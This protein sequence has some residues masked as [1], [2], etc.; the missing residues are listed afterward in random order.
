MSAPVLHEALTLLAD[1]VV[2]LLLVAGVLVGAV[3]GA[4]PGLS[5]TLAVALL[6]PFT[7]D[8]S[9]MPALAM[10]VGVYCGAIYGGSVPAILFRTPGTPASAATVT[11]GYALTRRGQSRRALSVAAFSAMVGGAIGTALLLLLAPQIASFAL[12]F[13]PPEYFALA[14][15]GLSMIVSVSGGSVLKSGAVALFGLLIATV[16]M[17][18]I[19]GYP[20]FLFG[21]ASLLEGVPFIPALIGLFALAEVFRALNNRVEIKQDDTGSVSWPAPA[22]VRRCLWTSTRSGLLGT[23][24]GSTPGAGSDIAAFM[25]YSV[26]RQRAKPGED[27]GHGEI[28]GV[29]A[30]EAAKTASIS[31]AMVPLLSLGIPGDSVTAVMIGAFILHGVQ[32]GPLL[33]AQNGGLAY[34]ILGTVLIAHLLVFLAAILGTRYLVRILAV[35]RGLLLASIVALS[36]LGA[37][38]LRGNI[39]DVWVAI[40]FGVVGFVLEKFSYPVAPLLLALILGPMAEENFRRS[41]ILSDGSY[42]AFLNHPLC[43]II[44][45]LAVLSLLYGTWRARPVARN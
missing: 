8:L 13:G 24:V 25:A 18:P 37:F 5:A 44:L 29:A 1:P 34:A 3:V 14:V 32:P 33:F 28:K 12:K 36:L 9:L 11:D 17:D 26:A 4:M 2:P 43:V 21:N 16:G 39:V 10:L 19:S 40:A 27:F 23:A 7:F 35:D 15:F 38:A 45:G 30:P 31:G 20:R 41:L 6:V 42:L 22:D